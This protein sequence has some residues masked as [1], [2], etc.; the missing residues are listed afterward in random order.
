[1]CISAITM[2]LVIFKKNSATISIMVTNRKLCQPETGMSGVLSQTK[3]L[4]MENIGNSHHGLIYCC[5]RFTSVWFGQYQN[6][7]IVFSQQY[8]NWNCFRGFIKFPET[9]GSVFAS[10]TKLLIEKHFIFEQV[11]FR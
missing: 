8:T 3:C 6:I 11:D 2:V 4:V 1:M 10:M 7:R 9:A 5:G